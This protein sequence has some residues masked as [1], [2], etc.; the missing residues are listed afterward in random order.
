MKRAAIAFRMVGAPFGRHRGMRRFGSLVCLLSIS[1]VT[2][3]GDQPPAVPSALLGSCTDGSC[4]G[5]PLVRRLIDGPPTCCVTP[6][7]RG[8]CS[9][10]APCEPTELRYVCPRMILSSSDG[11]TTCLWHCSEHL[12]GSCTSI[13]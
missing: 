5:Q 12:P 9:P 4:G 1:A 2:A 13:N 3:A 6:G 11:G 7:C 10:C 8:C